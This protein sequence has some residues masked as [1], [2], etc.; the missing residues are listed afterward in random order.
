[1]TAPEAVK[2][3]IQLSD[4]DC[5]VACLAMLLGVSYADVRRHVRERAHPTG[6][7]DW[8]IRRIAKKLGKPVQFR[9]NIDL[10]EVVGIVWL[11]RPKDANDP[12]SEIE[13]HVAMVLKG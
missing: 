8:Q 7:S 13:S 10:D 11:D 2:P 1:M 4:W 6:L 3:E 12:D 5:G 9:R